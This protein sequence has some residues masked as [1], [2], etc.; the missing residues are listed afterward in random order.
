MTIPATSCSNYI[1]LL[2]SLGIKAYTVDNSDNYILLT[3]CSKSTKQDIG[4]FCV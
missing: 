1:V 4:L 3:K 2:K